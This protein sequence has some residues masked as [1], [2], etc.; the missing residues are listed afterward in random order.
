ML[1]EQSKPTDLPG[2]H[3]AND[4]APLDLRQY[5]GEQLKL[6]PKNEKEQRNEKTND[7]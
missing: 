7:L 5:H 6:K 4:P 2:E 1:D 3:Q